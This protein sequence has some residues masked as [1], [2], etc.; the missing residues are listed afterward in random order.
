M[1]VLAPSRS[2]RAEDEFALGEVEERRLQ[3][4]PVGVDKSCV[5]AGSSGRDAAGSHVSSMQVI[6]IGPMLTLVRS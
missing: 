3:P 4:G 1:P 5:S 2:W 6:S